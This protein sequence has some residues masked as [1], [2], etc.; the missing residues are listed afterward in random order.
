[1]YHV[2]ING[3]PFYTIWISVLYNVTYQSD[4]LICDSKGSKEVT[5][6]LYK[7]I[8][9]PFY[10]II[11]AMVSSCLALRS[12]NEIKFG[13]HKIMIFITCVTLIILSQILSQYSGQ[14]TLRN[15]IISFLPFVITIFSYLTI[16]YRLN[17]NF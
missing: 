13:R 4:K 12:E 1:M 6:E 9:N 16:Q 11:I 8:I 17:K 14:I 3:I 15:I 7:R 10:I 5:K 2:Y